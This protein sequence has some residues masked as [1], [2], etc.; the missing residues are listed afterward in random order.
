MLSCSAG[1]GLVST[2]EWHS[3]GTDRAQ[4]PDDEV[5]REG[6]RPEFFWI[7]FFQVTLTSLSIH[8][9]HGSAVELN[10]T[11]IC[12]MQTSDDERR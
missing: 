8:R 3:T 7:S 5:A 11:E 12:I 1:S 9:I 10:F 6:L 4:T 2:I